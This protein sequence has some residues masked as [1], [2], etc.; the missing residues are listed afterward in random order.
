MMESINLVFQNMNFNHTII[1]LTWEV[2]INT[3]FFNISN[4]CHVHLKD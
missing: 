2:L 3:L 1:Q 4:V